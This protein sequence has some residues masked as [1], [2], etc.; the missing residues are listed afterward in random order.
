[1]K[2][3]FTWIAFYKEFA[4][5]ILPYRNNIR[6]LLDFIYTLTDSKGK[7]LTSYIKDSH[8]NKVSN[9]DPF[10]VVAIFN[11][12]TTWE[13]RQKICNEFKQ[14]LSIESEIPTDFSGIPTLNPMQSFYYDW[15]EWKRIS[16][17]WDLFEKVVA[18]QPCEQ[19]LENVLQLKTP[20]GMLTMALYWISPDTFLALDDRNRAFLHIYNFEPNLVKSAKSYFDFI[21]RVKQAMQA[22][23]IPYTTFPEFSHDAYEKSFDKGLWMWHG[24]FSTLQQSFIACGSSAPDLAFASIAYQNEM[25]EKYQEVAGNQDNSIPTMYW[26]FINEMKEGDT[27]VVFDTKKDKRKQYHLLYGYG[28]ISSRCKFVDTDNP[29]RREIV[30]HRPFLSSPIEEHKTKKSLYLHKVSGLEAY[31]I[32]K[33]LQINTTTMTTNHSDVIALLNANKNLILTGAP[34][35]GKTHMAMELAHELGADEKSICKVQ[36]HPSYDYTDFVEGIRPQEDGG[37]KRVDGE[38]KEFCKRAMLAQTTDDNLMVGLN[39][40]PKVW[41][42]S[43][44]G[45]GDNEIRRDCL[46]NGYIRIGW[47]SYGDLDFTEYNPNVTEGKNVL[48]AFQSA[49]QIGD[50]VVSCYSEK[51][52]DA[53]G[54]V[55]GDYEYDEK[56]GD[57]PR[58]RAVRWLAKDIRENILEINGGKRFTLSTV[59]LS[60][61]KPAAALEIAQKHSAPTQNHINK[62]FVFIIDEINRGELSKIFGELFGA[63]EKDY[64]GAKGRVRTQYQNMIQEGDP[65]KEGFYVPENVYIIGTMNDIDRSVESMDFAMRRRFAWKEVTAADSYTAIIENNNEFAGNKAEVKQRMERLNAEIEKRF[66]RAYQIGAAYFLNLQNNDFEALWKNHLEG[67]LFEYFRG[68]RDAQQKVDALHAIYNNE[69]SDTNIG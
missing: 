38:F 48:K 6:P 30:W 53:V 11:R 19:E 45:T 4:R 66:G 40:N 3:Q 61:I 55:T 12:N 47:P 44:K 43:L 13:N 58:F 35:T 56:G 31:N 22:G 10:S 67:L 52:T 64:R 28:T 62:P 36:F 69:P 25:I 21:G 41:K 65:F 60:N 32:R 20:I 51:E 23:S 29:L 68:E 7:S 26:H 33:L 9:I 46:D 42:V 37:F 50:I 59:Y 34:G 16:P 27:V 57:Y 49:M 24:D 54:I 5:R 1:M 15:D 2:T 14:F 17:L 8:K 63:I 18:G 39:D